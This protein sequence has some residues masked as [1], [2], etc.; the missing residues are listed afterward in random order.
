MNVLSS[1]LFTE[2]YDNLRASLTQLKHIMDAKLQLTAE[3]EL[4][5]DRML[6]RMYL[7]NEKVELK[8]AELRR[9]REEGEGKFD[10]LLKT[11]LEI[12]DNHRSFINDA[13]EKTRSYLNTQMYGQ[14][15]IIL[16]TF[17]FP[18]PLTLPLQFQLSIGK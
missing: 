15:Q 6:Y 5:K 11:K 13:N 12:I 14:M 10:N 8:T 18:S 3:E 17:G 1:S 9:E 4:L 2:E 16:M 7:D